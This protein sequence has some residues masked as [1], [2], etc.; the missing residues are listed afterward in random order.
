MFCFAAI[1]AAASTSA[2]PTASWMR[3][4]A[5]H[6]ERQ[7]VDELAAGGPAIAG[8]QA[9]DDGAGRENLGLLLV[10]LVQK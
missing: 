4:S 6:H 9:I 7:A 3:V 5:Q 10:V 8:P 1:N 2:L